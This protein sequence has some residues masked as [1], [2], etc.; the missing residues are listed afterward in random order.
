MILC[1]FTIDVECLDLFALQRFDLILH[2]RR[3]VLTLEFGKLEQEVVRILHQ[4]RN[5]SA[6]MPHDAALTATRGPL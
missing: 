3:T 4:A 1:A 6:R 2:P 5:E